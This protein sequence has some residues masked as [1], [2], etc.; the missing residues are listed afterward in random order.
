MMGVSLYTSRVVI[1]VLGID[2]FGIYNIVGGVIVLFS[3]V[4][5]SL[6]NSTQRFLSYQ[7]G[8][9]DDVELNRVMNV[10]LMCHILFIIFFL[11]LA[12]TIGYWFVISK[13]KIPES[14]ED[15]A[16]IVYLISIVTF[17]FHILQTPYQAAIIS[18]E[19]ISFYAMISILDVV[20]KL[21]ILF[22]LK[23]SGGD[24][25]I[26]YSI[27]LLCV[28]IISTFV[29]AFYCYKEL[30]YQ[31]PKIVR[32]KAL[33]KQFFWYSG[34]SMYGGCAYVGAQQGG[35]I[36]VNL[37]N[38]VAANGAFGI[39]NQVTNALYGF[40]SNFQVAFNPQIVKS[41]SAGQ[42]KEMLSLIDRASY[43][44]YY[45]FLIIAFPILSQI[46]YVLS[47]W[48]GAVPDYSP[49]F[50]RLLLVYFL[51]D[52]IEA[53][54]WMLIGATGKMKI[55]MLW[56]GTLTLLNIPISWMLLSF[57]WSI[58]W[59]FIIRVLLN[60][61]MAIIRPIH[62]GILVPSFSIIGYFKKAIVRPAVITFLLLAFLIISAK[63]FSNIHPLLVIMMIFII[64]ILTIWVIGM[65]KE[66]RTVIM[67]MI[68]NKLNK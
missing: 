45:I 67:N 35:N 41:Y 49:L 12:L 8:R 17:I 57:G 38:G 3:F 61:I 55:Y 50:C 39:A 51:V 42:T 40:V 4:S 1:Q 23:V 19:R 62:L 64:T 22:V 7:L 18:H 5:T 66:D 26:V 54:L 47:V 56:T 37:F 13:L 43:F 15:A 6:K 31:K 2:D 44:S 24:K 34:W 27:L 60:V 29:S 33:F 9:H 30:H 14:R 48:L 20:L 36:L 53:P 16:I 21:T 65:R 10:S 28:S 68:K 52:S 63:L 32:D 46:E 59:V 58:Y 25:L 11:I